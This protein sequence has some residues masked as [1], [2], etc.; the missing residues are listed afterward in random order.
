MQ[1]YTRL[2]LSLWYLGVVIHWWWLIRI[3]LRYKRQHLQ[4]YKSWIIQNKERE[5][6]TYTFSFVSLSPA[7]FRSLPK[8]PLA[9]RVS[10]NLSMRFYAKKYAKIDINKVITRIFMV[11]KSILPVPNKVKISTGVANDNIITEL[12]ERVNG[13]DV[14]WDFYQIME[15]ILYLCHSSSLAS[16]LNNIF[17][18]TNK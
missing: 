16:C 15:S 8:R 13:K 3:Q 14:R 5:K 2:V 9:Q 6:N 18:S 11:V 10:L 7:L 12:S 4:A 1:R 17:F